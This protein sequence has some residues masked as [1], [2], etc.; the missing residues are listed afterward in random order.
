MNNWLRWNTLLRWNYKTQRLRIRTS[1]GMCNNRGDPKGMCLEA[2]GSTTAATSAMKPIMPTDTILWT[3]SV[4]FLIS[5][6]D[7]LIIIYILINHTINT[8]NQYK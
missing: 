6:S 3:K 2:K 4:P 8:Y 7:N 1:G 5:T